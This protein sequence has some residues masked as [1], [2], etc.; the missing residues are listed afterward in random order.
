MTTLNQFIEDALTK[1]QDFLLEA[2]QDLTPEELAYRAGAGA[3]PIG[4]MLWHM[5]RVEDMWVQFFVQSK[6]ELW[7][8][9]GWKEKFGLPP[10]DNGFGHTPEQ[11][12]DFPALD[13]KEL[14]SYGAAIRAS[15][16]EFLRGLT[17]EDF[18]VVP[19]ER[20]PGFT[21]ASMFRQIIGEFYQH[22]GQIAYVKGLIRGADAF[23]ANYTAPG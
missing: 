8:A 2:V 19:R 23:A 5:Y 7:E 10:R 17:P 12:A 13:L 11:V 6:P 16:L 4:W 21:V 1:E 22:T 3:N 14:L 15:T 18:Q 9:E 20:R